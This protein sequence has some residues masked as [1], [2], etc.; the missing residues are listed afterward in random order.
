MSL[1]S[2]SR[3]KTQPCRVRMRPSSPKIWPPTSCRD[4]SQNLNHHSRRR[5]H[6]HLPPSPS[7]PAQET[8]PRPRRTCSD[9]SWTHPSP[10]TLCCTACDHQAPP[11]MWMCLPG[12]AG[13]RW[14]APGL[15]RL[16]GLATHPPPAVPRPAL[17]AR[18][19]P[20]PLMTN[21]KGC[22]CLGSV[23]LLMAKPGQTVM[24]TTD[25]HCTSR[26]DGRLSH[27]RGS[28]LPP[29]PNTL[30]QT[31]LPHQACGSTEVL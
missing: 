25:H 17:P 15:H 11:G 18:P 7:S 21:G 20:P 24:R 12:T 5:R 13:A 8:P 6:H 3:G 31:Q 29:T 16:H 22:A 30:L 23:F 28:S 14:S 26:P 1:W 4:T 19:P 10:S 2:S 27:H 9:P